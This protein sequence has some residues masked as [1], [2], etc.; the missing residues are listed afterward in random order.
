M[1]DLAF[2]ILAVVTIAGAILSLE[3]KE[4]VYGVLSLGLSLLGV[5]G[6][7]VLLDAPFPAMF[8]VTVYVGAVV[9]LILFT[10]MLVRREK[11]MQIKER[12]AISGVVGG[13]AVALGIGF[14]VVQAGLA[15]WMG[16]EDASVPY[17]AIGDQLMSTYWPV[18]IVLALVLSASIIGA[19]TLAKVETE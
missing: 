16:K 17:V 14:T 9:V 2:T 10:V 19:L 3:A 5:A 1:P 4:L 11:W 7:F 18:L 13:V 15:G 12:V 6:F 8:Q